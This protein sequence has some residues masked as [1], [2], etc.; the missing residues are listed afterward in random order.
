M[1]I[2]I[3]LSFLGMANESTTTTQPATVKVT[4]KD[5]KALCKEQGKTG[6][7]LV[8]CIKEKKTSD[9]E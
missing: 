7:D 3:L 2:L 6:K 5:A 9:V 4:I 8:S 1:K